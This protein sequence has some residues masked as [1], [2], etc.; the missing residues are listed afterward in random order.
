MPSRLQ[1]LARRSAGKGSRSTS[2][3]GRTLE[4]QATDALRTIA[5]SLA[6]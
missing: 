4:T 5:D 6:E 3:E 2:V 1:R